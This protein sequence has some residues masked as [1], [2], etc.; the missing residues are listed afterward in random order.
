MRTHNLPYQLNSFVGRE[1]EMA[2]I[3]SLLSS[4]RLVT[5]T[6]VGGTGKT[7]LALQVAADLLDDFA[8][9]VFFVALA[10][11]S[12]PILVIPTIAQ[13]LSVRE[14]QGRTVF[15]ALKDSLRAKHLLL[16]LDNFEH[17]IAIAPAVGELL[18]CAPHL[19]IVVT[20]REVLRIYGEHDYPVTAL[21]LPH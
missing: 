4:A 3:T 11:L 9:G 19:K 21:S 13:S 7:R 12:D 5:L 16:L 8:D 20:S 10:S 15:E 1:R 6:G 17:I 2:E 14:V 18:N